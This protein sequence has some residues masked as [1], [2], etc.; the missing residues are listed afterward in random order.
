MRPLFNVNAQAFY[1]FFLISKSFLSF[2]N[3]ELLSWCFCVTLDW[4]D[5]KS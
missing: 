1:T 4:T 5:L 2:K 3:I